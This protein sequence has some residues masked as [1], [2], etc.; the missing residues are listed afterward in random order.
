MKMNDLSNALLPSFAS[1]LISIK[2]IGDEE[3]RDLTNCLAKCLIHLSL[4]SCLTSTPSSSLS[5]ASVAA[6]GSTAAPPSSTTTTG[7]LHVSAPQQQQH[8]KSI[9]ITI[10]YL[11]NE[12]H[13][14]LTRSDIN[15]C[16]LQFLQETGSN[17][18]K[19]VRKNSCRI[20]NSFIVSNLN[21]CLGNNG[22]SELIHDLLHPGCIL[23]SLSMDSETEVRA[24]TIPAYGS[25][26]ILI[27]EQL[28]RIK[29]FDESDVN[30]ILDQMNHKLHF[31]LED[32]INRDQH[33]IQ[34]ELICIFARIARSCSLLN[35][36]SVT[37]TAKSF[38]DF[39]LPR[40][41]ALTVSVRSNVSL[42][43][44]QK[45]EIVLALID[46][47]TKLSFIPIGVNEQLIRESIMPSLKLMREEVLDVAPEYEETIVT[48]MAEFDK[49]LPQ[50]DVSPASGI[51]SLISKSMSLHRL[52]RES[53]G[54]SHQ[55]PVTSGHQM[56]HS[57]PPT[58]SASIAPS[59][60]SVTPV[61]D[62][63]K[64]RFKG[65]FKK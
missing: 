39:S 52:K 55:S 48:L 17:E 8:L 65:L 40:I 62:E 37:I 29:G 57:Q 13:S 5:S 2:P 27:H 58:P 38:L 53:S 9:G 44:S 24:L 64:T 60:P 4:E 18:H 15:R 36:D 22:F 33:M 61:M 50:H 47:Y 42:P 28:N 26:Y 7:S 56:A 10:N 41:A 30:Q 20:I 46:C 31:F 49:K 21:V 3:K 14:E 11:I 32:Q 23:D 51:E 59:V 6:S 1:L 45:Q 19:D 16:I 25:L 63:L 12:S 35:H 54:S 34:V 43:K